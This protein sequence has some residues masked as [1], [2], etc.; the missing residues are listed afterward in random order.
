MNLG[1]FDT[2]K[3]TTLTNTNKKSVTQDIDLGYDF[4]LLNNFLGGGIANKNSY[5]TQNQYQTTNTTYN[6]T[7]NQNTYDLSVNSVTDS[8][9]ASLK[10][11]DM[12]TLSASPNQSV[13]T[14]GSMEARSDQTSKTDMTG[15][16]ALVALAGI[17]VYAYTEFI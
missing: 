4:S 14:D 1:F 15:L 13:S 8:P 9:L 7:Y 12:G 11:G 6:T 3:S 16:I 2:I 10:K 5:Q 17:A